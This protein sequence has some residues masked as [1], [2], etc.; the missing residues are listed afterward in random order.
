MAT[1]VSLAERSSGLSIT[2]LEA[3]PGVARHQSGRNSGV[4]HSG[5]Y[6]QPGSQKADLCIDGRH[7]MT[8]FCEEY[9][10]PIER[11]GK[12]IVA[13]SD[14]ELGALNDLAERGRANGLSGLELV[15][16]AGLRKH[17]PYASGIR[18]LVVPEAGIV[19][20][21]RVAERLAS[22]LRTGGHTIR[23]GFDV[24]D[25]THSGAEF[26]FT[27]RTGDHCNAGY[28]V[29]CAGLHSDRIAAMAGV[30]PPVRIVP[31]R[32]EYYVLAPEQ[33][34]RVQH[35]VYPVPDPRFPFLGVHF[36]RRIDGS[37]E[38]G[39]N[40]VLA[41]GRHHYRG[42]GGVDLHELKELIGARELWQLGAKYWLTG[43]K[44]VVRSRSRRLY[45]AAARKLIPGVRAEDLQRGGSGI[46]AQAVAPDGTLVDDFVLEEA[47]HAMHVLNAP[48]PAATAALAIGHRIA[49]RI[50]AA[51]P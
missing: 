10:I 7:R 44:E 39:P 4:L 8:D 24:V 1:A 33:G 30:R 21:V 29:N 9:G 45:A 35:L 47:D 26:R 34:F 51:L 6:Y 11:T 46:R 2:V 31:F 41:L 37:V 27:S 18:A 32:G 48:S 25:I 43:T 13:T 36:T 28:L 22:L 40:A 23:T 12:V 42:E 5:V 19:D 14:S 20:F 50:L 16:A 49:N 3:E 38:V 15:D 17:E